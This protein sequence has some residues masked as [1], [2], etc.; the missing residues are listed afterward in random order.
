MKI[1]LKARTDFK[2]KN[3][4]MIENMGQKMSKTALLEKM[5]LEVVHRESWE[6]C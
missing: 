4:K 6:N 2:S 3:S 1:H 5:D